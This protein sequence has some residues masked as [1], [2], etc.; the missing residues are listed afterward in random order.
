MH[1]RFPFVVLLMAAL[2]LI[3][4]PRAPG[5]NVKISALPFVISIPGTHVLTS[6]LVAPTAEAAAISINSVLPGDVI[7][8]FKGFSVSSPTPGRSSASV[9]VYIFPNPARNNVI[10]RNG[11]ITGFLFDIEA[12]G[13]Q[14]TYL[15]NIQVLKMALSST[16]SP[17]ILFA[18]VNSSNVS[19]CTF[20]PAS[21]T[22]G[23]GIYDSGSLGGN[24]YTNNT[25]IGGGIIS[26]SIGVPGGTYVLDRLSF[27]APAS[28]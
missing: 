25:F 16:G 3:I 23:S 14:L 7:L 8:D 4:S 26:I 22:S 19:N 12:S 21:S 15:S 18:L 27:E 13:S 20:I 6:N 2:G 28:N 11:T 5:A 10:V 1:N 17:S 24:T 9:G